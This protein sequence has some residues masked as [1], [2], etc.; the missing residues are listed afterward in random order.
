MNDIEANVLVHGINMKPGK[1]TIIAEYNNK[2]FFGLPGQP[3]SAY[4]VLDN[5]MNEIIATIYNSSK[6]ELPYFEGEL[7]MNIH[8]AKGRRTYQEVNYENG[9]VTPRFTKAGMISA[10][11]K[12]SGYVIIDEFNEGLTAGTM[13]KVYQFGGRL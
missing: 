10:L 5:F 8:A 2:L 12:A 4:M 9:I 3:L 1:P 11:S 6:I 7:L 13:V